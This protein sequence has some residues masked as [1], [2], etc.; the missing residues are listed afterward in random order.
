MHSNVRWMRSCG[1]DN[2]EII[3]ANVFV[4]ITA[5]FSSVK[6]DYLEAWDYLCWQVET[7]S[8]DQ[9]DKD[10]ENN[11]WTALCCFIWNETAA[12]LQ[13][14]NQ[15]CCLISLLGI[16]IISKKRLENCVKCL[17]STTFKKKKT[18]NHQCWALNINLVTMREICSFKI[19]FCFGS[20]MWK[21]FLWCDT[22]GVSLIEAK[23]LIFFHNTNKKVRNRLF[24]Q[25]L[26][27]I[28]MKDNSSIIR[29]VC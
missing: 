19:I 20:K 21:T 4:N 25:Y 23:I 16:S 29:N 27:E 1:S 18:V 22:R 7:S 3:T 24:D 6:W 13:P 28:Y 8:D 26:V 15:E 14:C 11:V 9:N 2:P 5:C 12:T 10:V 17:F